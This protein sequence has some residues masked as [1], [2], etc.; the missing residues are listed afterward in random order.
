V[1]DRRR[2]YSILAR[3]AALVVLADLASKELAARFLADGPFTL[4]SWLSLHLTHNQFGAYGLSFGPY[5]WEI[6]LALTALA[7]CVVLPV[8]GEL[9]RIDRGAPIGLGLIAGAALGNLASLLL[10]KAG[11]PD[12]IAFQASSY[13][14]V[15][16]VA[17]VAAYAGLALLVKTGFRLVA[18]MRSTLQPGLRKS[19]EMAPRVPVMLVLHDREI[20]RDV[21]QEI[22]P[23]R[24]LR[25]DTGRPLGAPDLPIDVI[26]AGK[27]AKVLPFPQPSHV[28]AQEMLR[29]PDP[30]RGE[31]PPLT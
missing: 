21:Y 5:T 15:F 8:G 7:V 30:G 28:S 29:L 2:H 31:A 19:P 24:A 14:V 12:F 10:S 6:N 23:V 17:D 22:T 16:N 20:E 13:G 25:A 11:V 1:T 26:Q 9:G 4:T 18:E 3:T 27:E